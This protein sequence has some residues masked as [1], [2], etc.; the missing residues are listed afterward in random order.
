[1]TSTA[2]QLVTEAYRKHN[3]DE[4]SSFST[5]LTF[6]YNLAQ[7]VLN[8]TLREIDRIGNL[9]FMETSTALSYSAGV[10]TYAMST[11]LIDPVRIKYI[12]KEATNYWGELQQFQE[13]Q[14]KKRY[15]MAA[16]ATAQPSAWTKY[17]DTIEL[18]A[19]PD[20]DYTITV[21]HY[22]SLQLVTATSDTFTM[23][24]LGEDIIVSGCYQLLGAY[25]GKWDDLTA[26]AKLKQ[27]A[28]PFLV[29]TKG[30]A[31]LPRQMPAGF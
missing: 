3:L 12:R 28:Q 19:K 8:D 11:L 22:K 29:E 20:Q 7:N 6:P 18:D 13:R 31:G 9:T 17:G 5:S 15:R 30:D 21:Y 26:L 27:I 10:Y 23:P 4:V 2:I 16:V 25:I 24:S 14:F 1:M